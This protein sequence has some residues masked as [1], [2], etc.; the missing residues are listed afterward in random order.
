M[1]KFFSVIILIFT[2]SHIFP[3]A[4]AVKLSPLFGFS[5]G[6][7]NEL[8]YENDI[9]ESQLEWEN[10]KPFIGINTTCSIR[11]FVIDFKVQSAI[12]VALGN[13]TDKDFAVSETSYIS[14][15]SRHNL[16]TDKDYSFELNLS[17]KFILPFLGIG[18]G[19]TGA[20]SNIKMEAT[21]G[22]LQYPAGNKAWTGNES[23]DY[24]NGTVISY[25]QSRCIAGLLFFIQSEFKYFYFSFT[26]CFYPIVQIECID[27]HFL[28]S[29]QFLDHMEEG[30]AY[31]IKP[32]LGWKINT[33]YSVFIN[34]DF[35]YLEAKGNTRINSLGIISYDTTELDKS[36]SSAT[37]YF[38]LVFT[39]G[40][41]IKI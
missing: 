18:L 34:A 10:Y 23:K 29:V 4:I 11:S 33:K 28:R 27:N 2:A 38:D 32:H 20:Y 35:T 15:Y 7:I 22:Y 1:R 8:V 3:Q 17:Y 12:P 9:K 40:F 39:L 41:A 19:L 36:C 26:G 25:E 6:N 13:M 21:D 30:L 16:I 5:I 37:N 31:R 14:L 24:L